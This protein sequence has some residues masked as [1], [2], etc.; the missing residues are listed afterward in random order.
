MSPVSLGSAP[1]T[2]L[3]TSA[4]VLSALA[5]LPIVVHLVDDATPGVLSTVVDADLRGP[6]IGVALAVQ[7]LFAFASLRE[8]RAGHA[9]VLVLAAVWVAVVFVNHADAFVGGDFG[10]GFGSR[11][12][13]WGIVGLQGL[14][15]LTALAAL[16]TRRRTSFSGT[17]FGS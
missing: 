3:G 10:G 4:A 11:L 12:A 13:V 15:A 9:G 14:A 5:L 6:L 17:G 7:I 2:R 8:R 1:R 16:R